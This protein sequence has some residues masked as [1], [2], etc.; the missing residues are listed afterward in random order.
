MKDTGIIYEAAGYTFT[1]ADPIE[2]AEYSFSHG[3]KGDGITDL[4]V[5]ITADNPFTPVKT[6]ICWKVPV[7]DI[8]YKWNPMSG[9]H[10]YLDFEKGCYNKLLSRGN[11]PGPVM[12]LYDMAGTNALTFALDDAMHE[13]ELAVSLDERGF[14]DCS[15]GLFQSPWNPITEYTCVLRIDQRQIPYYTPIKD[16]GDWWEELGTK[17]AKAPAEASM[18]FFCT[19]YSH[20]GPV[21]PAQLLR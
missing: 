21:T 7:V 2:G 19:C 20:H 6:R 11:G 8:H 4:T 15:V 13:N 14:L 17:R 16:I 5:S 9:R 12:A 10:T 3:P 1:V 18:P